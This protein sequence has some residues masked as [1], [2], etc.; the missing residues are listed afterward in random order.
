MRGGAESAGA[1]HWSLRCAWGRRERSS[2]GKARSGIPSDAD[3]GQ[4]ARQELA[5]RC[6]GQG[7]GVPSRSSDPDLPGPHTPSSPEVPRRTVISVIKSVIY[8]KKWGDRVILS[9]KKRPPLSFLE[10]YDH[11]FSPNFCRRSRPGSRPDHRRS[12]FVAYFW[13]ADHAPTGGR[14]PNTLSSPQ[15]W[16]GTRS[17]RAPRGGR[18]CPGLN[19]W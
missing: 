7:P 4:A 18:A 19:E 1:P 17:C 14:R 10:F 11:A 8:W 3:F 13:P 5:D 9:L 2:C 16:R 15:V 12:R 6:P